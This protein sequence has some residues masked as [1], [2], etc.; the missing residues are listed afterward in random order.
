MRCK[1]PRLFGATTGFEQNDLLTT[2]HKFGEAPAKETKT[3]ERMPR[4]HSKRR[5][6]HYSGATA[7]SKL[8]LM[9]KVAAKP[10]AE[11]EPMLSELPVEP[12]RRQPSVVIVSACLSFRERPRDGMLFQKRKRTVDIFQ[13]EIAQVTAYPVADQNPLHYEILS[14][15]RHRVGRNLPSPRTKPIGKIIK[16]ESIV[17]PI[18][19]C[20]ANRGKSAVPIVDEAEWPH[21]A[22]LSRQVLG[23]VVA[24]VLN[25][26]VT[27]ET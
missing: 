16:S 25:L 3:R 20:P 1:A 11:L 4:P 24:G 18:S 19:E 22:D 9:R 27:F 14:L 2:K 12:L 15:R 7:G 8:G 5:R 23:R 21:S 26:S 10:G 17:D 6:E 13:Q